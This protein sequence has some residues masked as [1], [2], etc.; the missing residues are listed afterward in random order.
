MLVACSSREYGAV[1]V[2]TYA[3]PSQS[4]VSSAFRLVQPSD[5]SGVQSQVPIIVHDPDGTNTL[6]QTDGNGELTIEIVPGS[7]VTASYAATEEFR[8]GMAA[9]QDFITYLAVEPGDHLRFGQ[10]RLPL[11]DA[12]AT[13]TVSW[14]A[15]TGVDNFAIVHS[16]GLGEIPNGTATSYVVSFYENCTWYDRAPELGHVFVVGYDDDTVVMWAGFEDLQIVDGGS[17]EITEFQAPTM[18]RLAL[19]GMPSS[20]YYAQV[21]AEPR[22]GSADSIRPFVRAAGPPVDGGLAASGLWLPSD[23]VNVSAELDGIDF[24]TQ[25]LSARVPAADIIT[26]AEPLLPWIDWYSIVVDVAAQTI[27]WTQTDNSSAV[28]D[29]AVVGL[30]WDREQPT[31]ELLYQFFSWS[32][33]APPGVTSFAIPEMPTELAGLGPK[34]TDEIERG[35]TLVETSDAEGRL[36]NVLGLGDS[37]QNRADYPRVMTSV[38]GTRNPP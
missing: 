22:V 37:D 8:D 9:S 12:F 20:V 36:H 17:L 10:Q 1:R 38:A 34:L 2:T 14:P 16:C 27:E 15:Q 32:I 21:I 28:Y 18:Q 30:R 29:G 25:H 11:A 35:V 26:V 4:Q 13:M 5:G 3:P 19:T 23:E 6:Y 33:I 7:A 24:G 31:A